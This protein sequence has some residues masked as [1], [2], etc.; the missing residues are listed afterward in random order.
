[1]RLQDL[2][3]CIE[4]HFRQLFPGRFPSDRSFASSLAAIRDAGMLPS[5]AHDSVRIVCDYSNEYH[6]P[7]SDDP[8]SLEVLSMARDTLTLLRTF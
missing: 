5:E 8:D 3:I 4:S 7:D 6:H 1:V 2:R